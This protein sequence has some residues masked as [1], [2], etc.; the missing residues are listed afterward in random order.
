M[1]RRPGVAR[2]AERTHRHQR[3]L[4]RAGRVDTMGGEPKRSQAAVRV[5][6]LDELNWQ[7]LY[8]ARWPHRL[9]LD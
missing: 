6:Q 4:V 1:L 5:E 9:T 7:T 8:E 3:G 2:N